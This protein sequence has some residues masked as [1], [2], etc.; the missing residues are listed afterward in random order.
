MEHAVSISDK[1]IDILL[2]DLLE[3]HG[4]DFT[5]YSRASL[6]RRIESL[7]TKDKF[8]SF[9]EFRYK[10]RN[11]ENYLLRFVE[12]VT[13]TVTEMFRDPGF[14][15]T[16]RTDI[17]PVLAS[18]PVIRIWHAGCAT[19]EEVYSMAILLK[20][21]NLL[22]KSLLYA[23]DINPGVLEKIRRG[24]FPIGL[25]K[26]YS[27][28]YNLSGGGE[29]LSKYYTAKYEW[30]KFDELLSSRMIISTHNLV[31]DRSF[32]EFQLIVCRNVLIYFDK[33]LQNRALELFDESLETLGFLA[34]GSKETLRFSTIYPKYR[35]AENR[36]KIW[37]KMQP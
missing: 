14:Y 37:R 15:K 27:E 13:V 7:Y 36:E 17:L 4:Y 16:L 30:A 5:N 29:A 21:A 12:Q 26:Q 11:D 28:N 33:T 31:S 32:N 1:E 8:P 19:G 3:V 18:R 6:K 34:L 23:T 24:I 22:H 35:Q 10:L 9:A 25:I 2:A 20:E